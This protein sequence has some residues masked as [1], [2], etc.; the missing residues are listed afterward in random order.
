SDTQWRIR[1]VA[2]MSTGSEILQG[3]YADSNARY[4]A[5]RLTLLGVQCTSIAAAP[6]DPAA[7]E[8]VL[9]FSAANADLVI[10]TGGLGPTK[11]DVNR[12]VFERVLSRKLQRDA[13]AI[14]SMK[15]R[16][17]TRGWGDMPPSNEVQAMLPEGCVPLYNEWG[18][19]PGFL[20][21]PT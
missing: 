7:I 9:L 17:Q 2:L 20:V 5:E 12:F 15:A 3:Q 13:G 1:R 10:C 16:F 14:E 6:D 21:T 8:R 4:L 11:D 18:T 19:A